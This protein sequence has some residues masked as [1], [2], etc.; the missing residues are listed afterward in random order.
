M[1]CGIMNTIFYSW[2]GKWKQLIWWVSFLVQVAPTRTHGVSS[3]SRTH[4]RSF[5]PT[6]MACTN[7]NKVSQSQPHTHVGRYSVHCSYAKTIS[8]SNECLMLW[9]DS[10]PSP[11]LP[12]SLPPSRLC[13]SWRPNTQVPVSLCAGP[14]GGHPTTWRWHYRREEKAARWEV[15]QVHL[16]NL[17]CPHLW[18][19]GE[20]AGEGPGTTLP[21]V[22]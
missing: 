10:N 3:A 7:Y 14:E 15:C 2:L 18:H 19:A 11:S 8:A 16:T 12:P 13:S 22:V 5:G 9:T 20:G 17:G 6:E 21:C 1:V 4:W